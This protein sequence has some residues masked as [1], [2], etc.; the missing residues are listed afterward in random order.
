MFRVPHLLAAELPVAGLRFGSPT[1]PLRCLWQATWAVV[2]PVPI[3]HTQHSL[4]L[5]LYLHELLGAMAGSHADGRLAGG[6]CAGPRRRLPQLR[7]RSGQPRLAAPRRRPQRRWRLLWRGSRW[8]YAG[9][10]GGADPAPG[11]AP[12]GPCLLEGGVL[13][14]ASTGDPAA[15]IPCVSPV[16]AHWLRG[17][18]RLG[19][20]RPVPL[21]PG[22]HLAPLVSVPGKSYL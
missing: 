5:V 7:R 19:R 2:I 10:P 13:M 3:Q 22:G 8:H 4:I 11:R 21:H 18:R 12:W 17:P 16:A 6:T 20:R 1:Q 15:G 9:A 14:A